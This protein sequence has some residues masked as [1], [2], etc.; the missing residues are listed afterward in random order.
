MWVEGSSI[1]AETD[2][3][4]GMDW[5]LRCKFTALAEEYGYIERTE[6]N[7]EANTFTVYFATGNHWRFE[8]RG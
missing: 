4:L 1:V 8:I 5:Q 6:Y 3:R 2:R 7:A